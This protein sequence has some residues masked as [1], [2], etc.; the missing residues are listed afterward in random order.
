M[1]TISCLRIG[2]FAACFAGLSAAAFAA[3]VQSPI[4]SEVP[5][6]SLAKVNQS[7]AGKISAVANDGFSLDVK[8][9]DT[10]STLQFITDT[11]TKVTGSL[12]VGAKVSVEYRTD[13]DG[14]NI[15]TAV[16]VQ[17]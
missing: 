11:K 10:S 14:R 9:G 5:K 4:Q 3:P 17:S 1:K 13:A 2:V 12:S 8:V 6:Q 15:A 16:V 7:A